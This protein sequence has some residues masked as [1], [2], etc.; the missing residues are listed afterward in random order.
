[1]IWQSNL[2][3]IHGLVLISLF[4]IGGIL[5][6]AYAT[7]DIHPTVGHAAIS[8]PS[9]TDTAIPALKSTHA[10][11]AD[12]TQPEN[13]TNTSVTINGHEIPVPQNGS[14]KHQIVDDDGNTTIDMSIT[15]HNVSTGGTDTQN[16]VQVTVDTE[17]IPPDS[18]TNRSPAP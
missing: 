16:S 13:T 6:T 1:M 8:H 3:R 12:T 2:R 18:I 7:G 15:N 17:S 14:L 9:T 5:A 10:A 11:T 4:G